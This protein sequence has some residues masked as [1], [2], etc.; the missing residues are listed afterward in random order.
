M[1]LKEYKKFISSLGT[2]E[3]KDY[4]YE[5]DLS[6]LSDDERLELEHYLA[7]MK[8]KKVMIYLSIFG[9]LTI[10]LAGKP[11]YAKLAADLGVTKPEIKPEPGELPFDLIWVA[12]PDACDECAAEDGKI[13]GKTTDKIPELHEHCMCTF[14][15]VYQGEGATVKAMD[16]IVGKKESG[17][18]RAFEF[19]GKRKLEVLAAPFGS[20]SRRDRYNQWL[21]ART[22]FML[23]VGD[24][25][26][27]LYLHG[28][29]PRKRPVAK[30]SAI[31]AATVT[32]IDHL[33]L[34]METEIDDSESSDRVWDAAL[35]GTAR[36]STGSVSYLVR[37]QNRSDGTP[38]PGEVTVWPIAELSVFDTSEFVQPASDDAVVLPLRALF[39]Q[40]KIEIPQS[41][42]AGE[43]KG[44]GGIRAITSKD[45]GEST[46][47]P[48]E[49]K[50]INE[51]VAAALAAEQANLL[52]AGEVED[53]MRAKIL[54]E[55]KEDPKYRD[56][57]NINKLTGDKG[58]TAE[59]LETFSYMRALIEDG[60]R[61]AEGGQPLM[62][63]ALEESE[64]AELGPMVPTDLADQIKVLR[65]KYSLVR[66]TGM[67]VMQTDKL[68][69]S[70][71][72]ETTAV[73]EAATIAEE[74]AYTD[75]QPVFAAK[76]TTMLKKGGFIAVTEEALEDQD[77]FQAYLAKA[78]GKALAL[79]ENT[80]LNGLL[81]TV[82]G[83]E[84]AASHTLT[85]AELMTGYYALA[86]EY[87]DTAQWIMNDLTL[88][89]IRAM[90]IAT[91]RAYGEFGF[92]LGSMGEMGE[93]LM[94][95]RVF[96]N[97]NW[98]PI[99]TAANDVKIIDFV[100]LDEC[101]TWVERRGMSIFVDPYSQR[102]SAGTINFLISA[103]FNGV[104]TNAAALSGIDDH[105]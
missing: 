14:V 41:F 101:L 70:V 31:G 12:Q 86:Q 63:A 8:V 39:D 82:A 75:L 22:D 54:L 24:R 35:N 1:E 38:P 42:E 32:R 51:A 102:L 19:G 13:Y 5:L 48:E 11:E 3:L 44:A 79:A 67:S 73:T 56:T 84:V 10:M 37:P 50:A 94:N 43:D 53:A 90:L 52:K 59:K 98:D 36:A 96:T 76:P 28:S 93:T 57:F 92:L 97:A 66:K 45:L 61:V 80:V 26:P 60:K 65:G 30:P 91:P 9:F 27:T 2:Q 21:S 17:A 46:M 6:T 103:R 89:Y 100:E 68:T 104:V 40:C 34:W 88:A 49:L 16:I 55:L 69:F 25:R 62:R 83:V 77:L 85:D 105:A 99:T 7:D 18:V 15:K 4:L 23:E 47:T 72:T 64:A 87:R 74:G 58:L 71:P 95:H 33:G 20:E 81:V 29:S 78:G